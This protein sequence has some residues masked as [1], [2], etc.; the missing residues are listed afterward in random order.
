MSKKWKIHSS[1][2]RVLSAILFFFALPAS[3]RLSS[4]FLH[5]WPGSHQTWSCCLEEVQQA[6]PHFTPIMPCSTANATNICV[7]LK[8]SFLQDTH[9]RPQVP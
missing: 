3:Q 1:Q 2:H 8:C 7:H 6:F 9:Q 5:L 4:T